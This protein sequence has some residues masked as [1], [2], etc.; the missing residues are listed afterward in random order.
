[1]YG[2]TSF[3]V[4]D[5]AKKDLFL[6]KGIVI[7]VI[8]ENAD[9]KSHAKKKTAISINGQFL[10]MAKLRT[11]DKDVHVTVQKANPTGVQLQPTVQEVSLGSQNPGTPNT[12]GMKITIFR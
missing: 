3:Y 7:S 6:C 2:L 4:Y 5:K 12:V 11:T 10:P 9:K 8:L 1:M